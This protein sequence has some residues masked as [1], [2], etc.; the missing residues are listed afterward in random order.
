MFSLLESFDPIAVGAQQLILLRAVF[1]GAAYLIKIR[2]PF[3]LT[4]LSGPA[5]VNVIDVKRS[6][7]SE[8]AASARMAEHSEQLETQSVILRFTPLRPNRGRRVDSPVTL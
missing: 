5:P 1:Q 3:V 7:I 2:G 8:T 6:T 4:S